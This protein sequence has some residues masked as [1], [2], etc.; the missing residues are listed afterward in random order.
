MKYK[1]GD[2][3]K[4]IR[5][6]SSMDIYTR[7]IGK[8]TIIIDVMPNISNPYSLRSCGNTVWCDKELELANKTKF[9]VGD[10][11]KVL[12]SDF[13]LKT[14]YFGIVDSIN[15]LGDPEIK[16]LKAFH[17]DEDYPYFHDLDECEI[18][19]YEKTLDNLEVGDEVVDDN[20]EKMTVVKKVGGY[21]MSSPNDADDEDSIEWT[22]AE[23]SMCD[24]KPV[25]K[26]T[27]EI[28]GKKYY[29]EEVIDRVKKLK[30]VK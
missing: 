21:L 9:K 16:G 11:V 29:K 2:S 20:G 18:E 5:S 7:C 6:N 10:R 24:Y 19:L 13:D 8:T 28:E 3:V 26:E 17:Y 25:T 12:K 1:V 27:I 22:R 15:S 14:P 30:E 23:L 4:I